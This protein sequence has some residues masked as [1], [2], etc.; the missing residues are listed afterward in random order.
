MS[1]L[2]SRLITGDGRKITVGDVV[3]LYKEA[4]CISIPTGGAIHKL[5]STNY[6]LEAKFKVTDTDLLETVRTQK[7]YSL[8]LNQ[9]DKG[10]ETV[11]CQLGPIILKELYCVKSKNGRFM[12]RLEER[13]A[14]SDKQQILTIWDRSRLIRT[15]D[16]NDT[17]A[18]GK[19]NTDEQFGRM[20]WSKFGAQDK[21]LYV[22]QKKN[23]KS[24]SFFKRSS[25]SEPDDQTNRGD[26]YKLKE[27][28]GECL[29]AIEHTI[30][31]VLDVGQDCKITT[32]DQD[33]ISLGEPIWLHNCTRI[34]SV[35]WRECSRK[36]GLIYCNNRPSSVY[37]FDWQTKDSS[38]QLVSQLGQEGRCYHGIRPN[39]AG[40]KFLY[41]ANDTYGAHQHSTEIHLYD[42]I[43]GTTKKCT[44]LIATGD[45]SGSNTKCEQFFVDIPQNCFTSD[46]K[47]ILLCTS[48]CLYQSMNIYN[49]E[50]NLM[51]KID[52]PTISV[53]ILDFVDDIILASG[54][55]I[56]TT[57]TMFVA[58]LN[59]ENTQ[60][61]LPWHQ[62]EDCCHLDDVSYDTHIF[63]AS[64]KKSIVSTI[65][66]SPVLPIGNGKE[67]TMGD[68][69]LNTNSLPT[70]VYVHGGPHSSFQVRYMAEPI[71]YA[72]LGLRSLL[73]NYRGS[74]GVDEEYN[75][76]LCGNVG[77]MDVDDVLEAIRFAVKTKL[78]SPDKL[79]ISGGSHGG[80]LSCHL[81]CQDE[82]KFSSAI[83]RNP[84]TDLSSIYTISD[85][86]DWVFAEGLGFT[87]HSFDY[88]PKTDDLAQ[89]FNCSPM[90]NVQNAH[91][92]TLM[93]LG[94]KDLRVP[95]S[96][97]LRWYQIL[98]AK[99]V[100]AKC[101]VYSDKHSLDIP[102]VA[103]DA[104]ITSAIW[105]L[106]HIVPSK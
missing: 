102:E 28:W 91:V 95:M 78:I 27:S 49:F 54:S 41:L 104:F 66:I 81:S 101:K 18:H 77:K 4:H 62:I 33:G 5:N 37:V 32:I 88:V 96:Q 44:A 83:I 24:P 9:K 103:A 55:A 6:C 35:G 2:S 100:D 17:D 68:A 48:D 99:G 3:K 39:N 29:A 53:S 87:H 74:T 36:L 79:I 14:G 38:Q 98:K 93:L 46:D 15:L 58:K 76:S 43:N 23:L 69:S 72:R 30:L 73:V 26:E 59:L 20:T 71:L 90:S 34:A 10:I 75:T 67:V 64:D 106:T 61:I 92:P 40:D 16:I 70:V 84:V 86:P 63:P 7:I 89:L 85:I 31:A 1:A 19:I 13:L 11:Q 8:Q 105:I 12:A 56:N 80:F 47:N 60:D 65:I 52:F 82:F 94:D 21:L 97:G 50:T 42:L 51:L 45:G 22:C 57:P 25:C